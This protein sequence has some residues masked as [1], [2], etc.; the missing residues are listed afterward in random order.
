VPLALTSFWPLELTELRPLISFCGRSLVGTTSLDVDQMGPRASRRQHGGGHEATYSHIGG[1]PRRVG[2]PAAY[3]AAHDT[4]DE[5]IA[6]GVMAPCLPAVR[7]ANHPLAMQTVRLPEHSSFSK[8]Y[9]FRLSQSEYFPNL[10]LMV[11]SPDTRIFC[12]GEFL[13]AL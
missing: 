2:L 11:F 9:R 1:H 7:T 3:F 12:R 5:R 6:L 8:C 10:F 13:P 4:T